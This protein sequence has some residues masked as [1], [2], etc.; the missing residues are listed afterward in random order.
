MQVGNLYNPGHFRLL[1]IQWR[2]ARRR[3]TFFWYYSHV[4]YVFVSVY[5]KFMQCVTRACHRWC[6]H[7]GWV[8]CARGRGQW[9]W[10]F[11]HCLDF[12][13]CLLSELTNGIV[14]LQIQSVTGFY[15]F[16][17]KLLKIVKLCNCDSC[18]ASA[19]ADFTSIP[20]SIPVSCQGDIH[21]P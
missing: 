19:T 18:Y 1:N 17:L 11:E 15:N 4:G 9:R 16:L 12:R 13:S 14:V 2:F 8:V 10:E 5:F 21:G 20:R 3:P 7:K 6:R